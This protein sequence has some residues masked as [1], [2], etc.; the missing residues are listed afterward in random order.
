[1]DSSYGYDDEVLQTLEID[2]EI[3]DIGE[4]LAG[5]GIHPGADLVVALWEW[6]ESRVRARG[7]A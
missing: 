1:M 5:H 6:K 2:L 4:I 7:D 3:A